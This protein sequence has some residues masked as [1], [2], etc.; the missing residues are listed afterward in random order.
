M[1]ICS[2]LEKAL[3]SCYTTTRLHSVLENINESVWPCSREGSGSRNI[4]IMEVEDRLVERAQ[5]DDLTPSLLLQP[6]FQELQDSDLNDAFDILVGAD[7]PGSWLRKTYF[8]NTQVGELKE[9]GRDVALGIAFEIPHGQCQ[10]GLPLPQWCNVMR[11]IAQ[12]RFLLNA[13]SVARTGF[14]NMLLSHEEYEVAVRMDGLP[15]IFGKSPGFMRNVAGLLPPGVEDGA[16]FKP[17]AD[18]LDAM[19]KGLE[20]NLHMVSVRLWLSILIG[21]RMFGIKPQHVTSIVRI[22]L[23]VQYFDQVVNQVSRNKLAILVGDAAFQTHFWPGRGMNSVIKEAALLGRVLCKVVERG[24]SFLARNA[25]ELSLYQGYVYRLRVAEHN[26]RSLLFTCYKRGNRRNLNANT[27]DVLQKEAMR[28]IDQQDCIHKH[29]MALLTSEKQSLER[30]SARLPGTHEPITEQ[31]SFDNF[32]KGLVGG[33]AIEQFELS[34]MSKAGSWPPTRMDE[35]LPS[36]EL[37]GISKSS[38]RPPKTSGSWLHG[39][40][41]LE[42]LQ[43]IVRRQL[44]FGSGCYVKAF[45][46]TEKEVD[47]QTLTCED[48]NESH[49][50]AGVH[51]KAFKCTE[52][53]VDLQILT[54]E[55]L[56]GNHEVAGVVKESSVSHNKN[57]KHLYQKGLGSDPMSSDIWYKLG[58][59]GGGNVNGRV[60]TKKQCY[61]HA[62]LCDAGNANAWNSLGRAGGGSLK[63][64]CLTSVECYQQALACNNKCSQAWYNLGL[65][66]GG[67]VNGHSYTII[68]CYQQALACDCKNSKA[69]N[70]LGVAGGGYVSGRRYTKFQCYRQALFSNFKNTAANRNLRLAGPSKQ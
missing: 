8:E 62:L 66:G 9:V 14:L 21:L 57:N 51:V 53:E 4:P 11:T 61:Q 50:Y 6:I 22:Q 48:L 52:K 56:K 3:P 12:R 67:K 26:D 2:C 70:N 65:V 54:C 46:C 15:C 68:Q 43:S 69:W 38:A 7:G 64:Y 36:T 1:Y 59:A 47:L 60:C 5:M 33:S 24:D 19:Y 41:P 45:N 58:L 32:V 13:S 17:Q 23:P 28:G 18:C 37:E 63:G 20:I 30:L 31:D 44:A 39:S 34:L 16:A 27:L 25:H 42:D 35:V 10:Y 55:D 49:E 40:N 29:A